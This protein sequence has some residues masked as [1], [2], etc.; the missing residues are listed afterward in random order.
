MTQKA[1][2]EQ[3]AR[4]ALSAHGIPDITVAGL[5]VGR[6]AA[7]RLEIVHPAL[8]GYR[9]SERGRQME[10]MAPDGTAAAVML[11][12]AQMTQVLRAAGIRAT[13]DYRLG[14]IVLSWG[15]PRAPDIDG[16]RRS[17]AGSGEEPIADDVV[18]V[19]WAATP[20]SEADAL[21]PALEAAADAISPG[22]PARTPGAVRSSRRSRPPTPP[23]RL[24]P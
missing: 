5:R 23:P 20:A 15:A 13:A 9:Q 11:E 1:A 19:T 14:T 22:R 6:P 16:I 4:S 17:L 12:L 18:L 24:A 10:A 7:A 21:T 3:K 8:S 2:L